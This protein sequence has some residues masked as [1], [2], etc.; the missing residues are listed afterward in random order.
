RLVSLTGAGGIGK[1]QLALAAARQ[2]VPNFSGGVWLAELSPLADPGLLPATVA[3]AV[4][5]ELGGGEI[6]AQRV[7]LALADRRLLLVLDTCE[8]VIGAAAGMVEALLHASPAA[9]V[10]ATSREPLKAE[11]E[12]IYL[13]PPLAVPAVESDNF[14]QYGA[15]R[16][17]VLRSRASGAHV[18]EDRHVAAFIATI[19][20]RLDGIPLAIE[21]AAARGGAFGIEA[22]A[23]GL[24]DRF[25]LLTGGRRM[26]LL[27]HQTLRATLDWSYELLSEPERVILRRLAIFA[28]VFRLE[29]ASTVVASPELPQSEVVEGLANLVAKS[30]VA[31][32]VDG[33]VARYRLLDTTR[34]Y[35]IEKLGESGESERLA[36]RHAEYYKDF[37][38]RA[39]AAL[40]ARS[41]V[42]WLDDYG[43]QIDN[44]RAA[45]D[46]AFSPN[47]EVSI[48]VALTAAA[49]PL[50][51]HLSL[52]DECRNRVV[53]ALAAIEVGTNPD[54][55]LEMKLH[56][57]LGG[58]LMYAYAL[59][60]AV[61]RAG[62]AWTRAFEIAESLDDAEYRLTS[63]WGLW[64]FQ[65]ASSGHRVALKLAERFCALAANGPD[66]NYRLVGE[67][68]MAISQHYL[69][70]LPSA[71]RHLDRALGEYVT[72]N[73]TSP[74]LRFQFR[75]HVAARVLLAWIL[76]LEGFPDQAIRAAEKSVEEARGADHVISLCYA[77]AQACAITLSV[78]DL[79]AAESYVRVLVDQSTRH[80]LPF[81]AAL[82]RSHRGSLL[83]M[84]GDVDAGLRLLRAGDFELGEGRV[85]WRS[86]TF[87]TVTAEALGRTGQIGDGLIMV[88][89]AIDHCERTEE[90]WLF[91]E[92]L[93][94]KSELLLLQSGSSA[95][96]TAE[97]HFRQALDWAR[98]QGALSWELRA[99]TSFARLL[100]DQG[101]PAEAMALL[102]PVY[103]RFT[104]G[105]AT[106]D[107]Q[108]AKAIIDALQ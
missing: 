87:S 19:C 62:A 88:E 7:A 59:K 66:P 42:E 51:M 8:H 91:P 47:G 28:G 96:A 77:L 73:H 84:R 9:H 72:A 15:A 16:L 76:W 82:G 94:V 1:T 79:A 32:E 67:R 29:A 89:A 23:A 83:I 38:E 71:R 92:L 107:L 40:D 44:L 78:G 54:A 6:S 20:R 103:D 39:E 93:R 74:V 98:R 30:L 86:V 26:A 36:R 56:A 80:S 48:G 41:T 11:G 25:R 75:P 17:F 4:G 105:F 34:A 24:D 85:A 18:S 2:V 61:T 10:I 70:D 99:A 65:F 97:D 102:Q 52:L 53:R 43:R 69:G 106:V 108:A 5:L 60:D 12:W 46:W 50:W 45:L 49:V 100:R 21:L 90:L 3:A 55:R 95:A 63:L 58:L 64:F 104:E 22:L 81:W 57:A 68:M 37:F 33:R 13:V 14:W 101:R 31:A 27:R 35:A